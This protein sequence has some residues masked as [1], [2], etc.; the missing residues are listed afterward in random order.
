MVLVLH[1]TC[2]HGSACMYAY[3][4]LQYTITGNIFRSRVVATTLVNTF[5]SISHNSNYKLRDIRSTLYVYCINSKLKLNVCNNYVVYSILIHYSTNP[6]SKSKSILSIAVY[7]NDTSKLKLKLS[8]TVRFKTIKNSP[9][10]VSVFCVL[11]VLLLL[12]LLLVP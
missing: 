11:T 2:M 4:I 10:H 12:S 6:K 7:H 1:S 3:G 9:Q 5:L 8:C